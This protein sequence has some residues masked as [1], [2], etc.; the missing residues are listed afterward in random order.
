MSSNMADFARDVATTN[1][2]NVS[3][4]GLNLGPVSGNNVHLESQTVPQDRAIQLPPGVAS[5]KTE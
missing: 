5:I 4:G 3:A 1:G 2:A